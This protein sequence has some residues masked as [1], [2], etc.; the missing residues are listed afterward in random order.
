MPSRMPSV[1]SLLACAFVWAIAPT[2]LAN[3]ALDEDEIAFLHLI[4]E[5]RALNGL[6]CLTPSPTMNVAADWMSREMGEQGFFSHQEPPCDPSGND[7]TGRD[8]FERITFFEHNQWNTAGENIAAGYPNAAA[9]FEGWRNSPGHNANML[10]GAFTA[11]GI[12]RVEVPGSRFGIYWTNNFS[13]WIDGHYDCDGVWHGEGGTGG[14][15]GDGGDGGTGGDG[16][17]GGEGGAGGTGGTGGSGGEG[18]VGG[19]GGVGGVLPLDP[20]PGS[21]WSQLD[22]NGSSSSCSVASGA[23]TWGWT[24]LALWWFRSGTARRRPRP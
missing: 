2:A 12:G 10:Q 6:G 20:T 14:T 23:S 16:G 9:V 15:G 1:R 8:P 17:S 21:F 3:P 5:Y 18:G 4:N 22:P 19:T 13:D 7:C 24:L 11:I